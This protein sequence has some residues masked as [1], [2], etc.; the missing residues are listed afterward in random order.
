M[1]Q[2][3]ILLSVHI[4]QILLMLLWVWSCGK[5]TA[6]VPPQTL[7]PHPINNLSY[8]LD[9]YGA[10]L[11]WPRPTKAINGR[12]LSGDIVF[13]VYRAEVAANDYCPDCP[14][15]YGSPVVEITMD[16]ATGAHSLL[17]YQDKTV[18]PDYRYLYKVQPRI[19]YFNA[20]QESNT[21]G[22]WWL[23]PIAAPTGL[24]GTAGDARVALSWQA[25]KQLLD[26][27]IVNEKLSYRVYRRDSA[28][29]FVVLADISTTLEFID[30]AVENGEKY[31]YLVRA[32]RTKEDTKL[33]G[34]AS[35]IVSVTPVDLTPPA[36]P[37]GIRIIQTTAGVK[38]IWD[39]VESSDL[40]GFRIYRRE[41]EKK[42]RHLIG[43]TGS[44]VITYTDENLFHSGTFY[45]SV[46]AID[47]A[48]PPNESLFIKEIAFT[49][50]N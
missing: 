23:Q 25:P 39:M 10:T 45:Y 1:K 22:F 49:P 36:A 7:L 35:D 19:G 33:P 11:T 28:A 15:I 40:A 13:D 47:N 29:S 12:Q 32:L 17:T 6:P 27:S 9:E 44:G 31:S 4:L 37:S 34:A 2:K 26:G 43:T 3:S 41:A 38:L 21:V 8:D 50:G 5:K 18:R 30:V 24:K 46:T 42:D 16:H 14:V 48:V 20:G